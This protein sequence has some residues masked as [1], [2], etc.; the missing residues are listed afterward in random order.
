MYVTTRIGIIFRLPAP[1][2]VFNG[3]TFSD[4][5]GRVARFDRHL[6]ILDPEFQTSVCIVA[7]KIKYRRTLRCPCRAFQK[8]I[9]WHKNKDAKRRMYPLL[10]SDGKKTKRRKSI[11]KITTVNVTMLF[12]WNREEN[13]KHVN[14]MK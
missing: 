14:A 4:F 7:Q 11:Q 3:Y 5:L 2:A 1:L 12:Y 6:G 10:T 8:I 9:R 13:R